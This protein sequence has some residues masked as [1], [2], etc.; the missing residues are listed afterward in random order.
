MIGRSRTGCQ[1]Y[2]P[3]AALLG[4]SACCV[5]P[6]THADLL[7]V[8]F[9]SPELTF[10]TFQTAVRADD[11]GAQRRCLAAGFLA[12]HG[13]SE[14]GFR[15]FWEILER[16]EPFL[17]KGIADAEVSSPAEVRGD[18]ARLRARSHGRT[19]QVDLRR[20]D[21]CEAWEGPVKRADEAAP[22]GDRTGVQS[23]EDGSRWMY[24]RMSLPEGVRPERI[25]ELRFGREWKIDGFEDLE[26]KERSV[27]AQ[28]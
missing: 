28:P 18:R 26:G 7:A 2:G 20:E 22:F 14:L 5:A 17:R 23:G 16:E 10:R 19:L 15:E 25:T 21:F 11:P 12:R 3:V 27:D 1:R 8:G 24:G 9:R 4:I 13:L 6:P